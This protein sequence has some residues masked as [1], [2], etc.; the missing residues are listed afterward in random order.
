[1]APPLTEPAGPGLTS[2]SKSVVNPAITAPPDS[3]D[4]GVSPV[5]ICKSRLL[6]KNGLET[7]EFASCPVASFHP[8][9]V[10]TSEPR[11]PRTAFG[12][13]A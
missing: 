13:L 7:I 5:F 8:A 9:S 3:S 12:P 11:K 4:V 2:P 1:M 6:V 10:V